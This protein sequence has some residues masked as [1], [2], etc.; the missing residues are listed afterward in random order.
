M[1]SDELI[2]R[3]MDRLGDLLR[4]TLTTTGA[5]EVPLREE[6]EALGK[7]L[8]IEHTRFGDRLTTRLEIEPEALDAFVPYLLLQ[9]LAENAIRHGVARRAAAGC[10]DLSTR[11]EDGRL[12]LR[13][14]NDGPVLAA[15]W[16]LEQNSG[17][18]LR[19]SV[20]RLR[21]LYG[22]SGSLRVSNAAE[23]GVEV[24][25]ELPYHARPVPLAE[26]RHA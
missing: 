8:E 1:R 17:I 15:G 12:I 22:D 6:L 26:A 3:M 13:L 16:T 19:N 24:R 18:G 4:M 23:G 9:P 10:I 20:A 2:D 21:H 5:E 11:R 7:Y 14:R 25:I